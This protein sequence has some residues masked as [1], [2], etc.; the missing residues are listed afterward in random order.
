MEDSFGE[1]MGSCF[2]ATMIIVA[3]GPMALS[4]LH[5]FVQ[6]DAS[7]LDVPT[8]SYLRG[9]LVI[10]LIFGLIGALLTEPKSKPESRESKEEE[11]DPHDPDLLYERLQR[12]GPAD[13]QDCWDVDDRCKYCGAGDDNHHSFSCPT[14]R[15]PD[16]VA[17]R[18][19]QVMEDR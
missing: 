15:H 8:L 2:F 5:A 4:L 16:K 3:G 19:G 13:E 14:E 18:M 11:W 17:R 1:R 12:R 9:A 7:L 6:W 10:S